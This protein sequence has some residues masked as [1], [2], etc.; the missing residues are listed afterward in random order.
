M[1]GFK[2][3]RG[4]GGSRGPPMVLLYSAGVGQV[5]WASCPW[6]VV[7]NKRWPY[8]ANISKSEAL[9]ATYKPRKSSWRRA[10]LPPHP[11]I[12]RLDIAGELRGV[13]QG[14]SGHPLPE[15]RTKL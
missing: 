1:R 13:H 7:L 3:N 14:R 15:R 6:L 10:P 4:M 11:A 5:A 8:S 9:F 12:C 2:Q